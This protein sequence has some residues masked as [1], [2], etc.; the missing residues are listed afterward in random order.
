MTLKSTKKTN[1]NGRIS[2]LD[3][4]SLLDNVRRS[5]SEYSAICPAHQD[6]NNSLTFRKKDDG[7]V[8][9]NCHSGC[10]HREIVKAIQQL[11]REQPANHDDSELTE[12]ERDESETH[13]E[14]IDLAEW[15]KR[16]ESFEQQLSDE[17]CKAFAKQLGVLPKS[18]RALGCGWHEEKECYTI[19]ERNADGD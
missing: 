9:F 15:N 3:C 19:P 18:I 5:G 10:E 1:T 2:L 4:Q 11:K 8:V 17:Q 14:S 7:Q 12:R 16:A 13:E 6:S